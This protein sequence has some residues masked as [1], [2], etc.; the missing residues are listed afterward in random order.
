MIRLNLFFALL[1]LVLALAGPRG[2]GLWGWWGLVAYL[3]GAVGSVGPWAL[4][5]I[6]R[7]GV[8]ERYDRLEP[9][10]SKAAEAL[11]VASVFIPFLRA[12]NAMLAGVAFG[13]WLLNKRWLAQAAVLVATG[14]IALGGPL[15]QLAVGHRPIASANWAIAAAPLA[16]MALW[17]L[18]RRF[19][20][21]QPAVRRPVR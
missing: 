18:G 12:V 5:L 10:F 14:L 6:A 3:V 8:L 4:G 2:Y 16:V 21:R 20:R 17:L 9:Q 13:A 1:S 19:L 15:V 11:S 7:I